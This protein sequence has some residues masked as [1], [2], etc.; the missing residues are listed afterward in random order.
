MKSKQEILDIMAGAYGTT[1]YHTFSALPGSPVLTD[2][3]LQVAKAGECYWF[4]DLIIRDQ[5]NPKLSK[6]FQVWKLQI[7][8][9]EQSAVVCGYNDTKLIIKYQIPCP[10]FPLDELEVYLY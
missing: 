3:V 7:N 5:K 2:G 6:T 1:T 4:F 8:R 10:N 9:N